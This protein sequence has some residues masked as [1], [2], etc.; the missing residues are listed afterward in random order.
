MQLCYRYD[1]G[2]KEYVGSEEMLRDP[3]E[4]IKQ[5]KDIWV[6]PADCTLIP[7]PE[8]KEGFKIKWTGEAWEYEEEKKE[9]KKEENE[10]TK[11]GQTDEEKKQIKRWER[12]DI[13]NKAMERVERY[14]TQKEAGLAT[15]DDDKTYSAL[16]IYAQYLRDFPQ[17]DG[18]WWNAPI[19]TFEEWG[20]AQ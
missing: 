16:L 9:E 14:Q 6:L 15:T 10:L 7:P 17:Q 2:K 13:L 18:E 20:A 1:Q 19:L 11:Y 12:N 5:K 3:L 4:T 8:A